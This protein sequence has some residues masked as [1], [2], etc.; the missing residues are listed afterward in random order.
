MKKKYKT[1]NL[2]CTKCGKKFKRSIGKNIFKIKCPKC[3]S[4]DTGLALWQA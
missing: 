1:L 4:Y 2:E 3:G